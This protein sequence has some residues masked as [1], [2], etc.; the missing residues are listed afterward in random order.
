MRYFKL[1]LFT[2]AGL[3]LII[4]PGWAASADDEPTIAGLKGPARA[5]LGNVAQVDV[6]ANYQFLDGKR[7][8]EIMKAMGEPT[9]GHELG[10][11]L[12][13][14]TNE[15]CS[16][17]FEFNDAGYVKDDDKDKL[18]PDK[19]LASFKRGTAESNKDRV[20]AGNPPLE[21]VGWEVPPSYD[22][23]THN[24]EWAIRAT[25]EGQPILNYNTRLLGRKGVMEVVLIVDPD[26]LNETLP[27]FRNVLAGYTFQSGQTYA[28]YRPGDKVAKYGLAGLV[29]AGA[30]V[31]A[32]KLGLFG[33]LL[34]LL[35]K[36]WKLVVVAIAAIAAAIK[37]VFS[38]IFGRRQSGIN[39]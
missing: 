17:I 4:Q 20:R 33:P 11:I 21:I 1:S 3:I 7:T 34:L 6:P 9:S 10:W 8:R 2:I 26:K 31:G 37:K 35:K 5:H 30:A 13:T 16:V 24:L 12:P 19:L 18:D 32:A 15:H 14:T 38:K 22:A 29:L 23:T 39:Q 27:K 36:A 28:E 25:S